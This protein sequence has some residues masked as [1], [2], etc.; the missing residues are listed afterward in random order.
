MKAGINST[1]CAGLALNGRKLG[2]RLDRCIFSCACAAI[3]LLEQTGVT[4]VKALLARMEERRVVSELEHSSGWQWRNL[5][6][7]LS[8]CADKKS[9]SL[10]DSDCSC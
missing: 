7:K 2:K 10:M 6:A 3:R 9:C 1:G 8:H 4:S 5:Q